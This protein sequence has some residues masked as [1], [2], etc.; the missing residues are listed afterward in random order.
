MA[1]KTLPTLLLSILVYWPFSSGGSDFRDMK[2]FHHNKQKH[3]EVTGETLQ[4]L[5]NGENNMI[6]A[7]DHHENYK[8][9]QI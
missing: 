4:S 7:F 2:I 5:K 8:K 6:P 1:E 3:Q 9:Q